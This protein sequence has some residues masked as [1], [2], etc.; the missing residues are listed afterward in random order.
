MTRPFSLHG[1]AETR[2]KMTQ[3]ERFFASLRRG[4]ASK[5]LVS[6]TST[7]LIVAIQN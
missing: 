2:Q 3:E 4:I 5:L 6:L 7:R 1:L